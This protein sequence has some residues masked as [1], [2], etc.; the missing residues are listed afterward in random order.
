M[1][2]PIPSN[3]ARFSA[4]ELAAA[5]GG[6]LLGVDA[7]SLVVGVSTDS[8]SVPPGAAFFALVGHAHDGHRFAAAARERGALPVVE[9]GRG[10]D[11]PRIEVADTLTALGDLARYF[12]GR[13]TVGRAVP[14]LA[15]GGAA[16]KTTTKTLAAAAVSAL[17]G[18][19]LVTAGNLNNRIGVPMTLLTLDARHRAIVLECGTSVRGE[20]AELGRIARPDVAVVIN[21]GVEHS[22]GLGTLDQIADEEAALLFAAR[23]AAVANGD[24][25]LLV[26]RHTRVSAQKLLFGLAES[27]DLR[28]ASRSLDAA[29]AS[30]VAFRTR[31]SGLFEGLASRQE[32]RFT[33]E[34]LGESAAMNV[35]A[36]VLAAVALL[37]RPASADEV[38]ALRSAIAGVEAV[39]GRLRPIEL[40]AVLVIDDS[41][42]ANPRSVRAALAATRELATRR[43]ARL[44]IALGDMLEL[45]EVSAGEHEAMLRAADDAGAAQLVL[46]GAETGAA[47]GRL[48]D[49][50][51][52][53]HRAFLTSLEAAADLAG[54]VHPGDVLLV[55]GSRGMRMERL[56]EALENRT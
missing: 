39:P 16:G 50:L 41:Y 54:V 11:G 37:G 22:A 18:E 42:N 13:E 27:C 56:I 28:L 26:H 52:T 3:E 14:V 19:T 8:R 47:L 32:L 33:T 2:T 25:E 49:E 40:G 7:D 15:I 38:E 9:R 6:S 35:A 48:A 45:G 46:V 44:V 1:A 23:R 12:V 4:G 10:V 24:D 55:K 5:T 21:V 31:G 53:P 34:L 36:A 20:I 43:E 17:C 29:G 30:T 51:H